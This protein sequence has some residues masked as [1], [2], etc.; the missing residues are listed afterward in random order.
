MAVLGDSIPVI[1]RQLTPLANDDKPEWFRPKPKRRS[2]GG[3]GSIL[4]DLHLFESYETT[5]HHFVQLRQK[6]IDLVLA[7]DNFDHQRQVFRK[8][9]DLRRIQ[10]AGSAQTPRTAQNGCTGQMQLTDFE[11]DRLL[12]RRSTELVILAN[13]NAE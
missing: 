5:G 6:A 13:E 2:A 10:P 4:K 12:S 8:A 1:G 3:F 7:I 11:H 9:Q